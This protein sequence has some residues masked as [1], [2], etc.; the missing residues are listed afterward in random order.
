MNRPTAWADQGIC[1][2][3]Y[4]VGQLA[5][6]PEGTQVAYCG[7]CEVRSQ[8]LEDALAEERLTAIHPV[9]IRGGRTA[10][11]RAALLKAERVNLTG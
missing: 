5:N 6:L 1:V 11:Q 3:Q 10:R 4:D 9:G 2:T 7:L 8:C